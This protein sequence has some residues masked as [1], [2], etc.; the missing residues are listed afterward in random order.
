[1]VFM[2]KYMHLLELIRKPAK[3]STSAAS[4]WEAA[5]PPRLLS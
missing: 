5:S 2:V 4:P 3:L 1:M